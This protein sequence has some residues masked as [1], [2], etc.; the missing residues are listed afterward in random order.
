MKFKVWLGLGA[1]TILLALGTALVLIFIQS[2]AA[3]P[4]TTQAL[5]QV[6]G[7][8]TARQAYALLLQQWAPGW[9][10]DTQLVSVSASLLK[11]EGQSLGWSFQVYS[12]SRQK[13]AVVLVSP[14]RVWVLREKS[15]PYSQRTITD[16]A[17]RLDSE[18][19]LAQWWERSGVMLWSQPQ[20]DSLYV[21]LRSEKD[22]ALVWQISML[23]KNGD[24]IGYWG[25]S[26]ADG[27]VLYEDIPGGRP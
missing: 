12:P 4:M 11:A 26:A 16:S 9:A 6:G 18:A 1:L 13:L 27:A 10:A 3:S 21:H 5:P 23:D 17:W 22:G 2:Q 20:V 15:I 19:L 25:M 8:Q 7:A 14:D 24:L